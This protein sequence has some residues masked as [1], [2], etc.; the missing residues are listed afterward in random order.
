VSDRKAVGG[1]KSFYKDR[2]IRL[3]RN[4]EKAELKRQQ[5][6]PTERAHAILRAGGLADF[7]FF[8]TRILKLKF[9]PHVHGDIAHALQNH[10]ALGIRQVL[11][12]MARGHF[13]STLVAA[14]LAW[15]I[16]RDRDT[17][18]IAV[19]ASEPGAKKVGRQVIAFLRTPLVVA[20][21]GAFEGRRDLSESEFI[22]EGRS[23]ALRDATF[24]AAG[25][26]NFRPGPHV[27]ALALDDFEDEYTTT[28]PEM[29]AKGQDMDAQMVPVTDRDGS[30]RIVIGTFKSDSDL[31]C[32]LEEKYELLDEEKLPDGRTIKVR[33]NGVIKNGCAYFYKPLLLEDGT[34]LF[35]E[36]FPPEK[37]AQ[38]KWDM[39]FKPALFAREY[40]LDPVHQETAAF[41]ESDFPISS[42]CPFPVEDA[43]TYGAFDLANT[44]G[45]DSARTGQILFHI[46][47]NFTIYVEW[48][49]GEKMDGRA[50]M[51][52]MFRIDKQYERPTL[53][54]E[55]ENYVRGWKI[56]FEERMRA[57][58]NYLRTVY[59]SAHSRQSKESRILGLQGVLRAGNVTFSPECG[60][61]IHELLRFP[62]AKYRD[63]ADAF[64]LGMEVARSPAEK[65]RWQE[66]EKGIRISEAARTLMKSYASNGDNT[67]MTDDPKAALKW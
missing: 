14:F 8:S 4:D 31:H 6:T 55:E 47:P 51:D 32:F 42:T 58:R 3:N 29:I 49:R 40:M 34:P 30:I 62:E 9:V 22:V 56:G 57:E 43:F 5:T 54:I 52:M 25:R 65:K 20:L 41:K 28:T 35:P 67:K 48:A 12:L 16:V 17:R 13:K 38:I 66:Y 60:D 46:G 10:R 63:V 11:I 39:R 24:T 23:G 50:Q 1:Q 37:I 19:S 44:V 18:E 61:L 15:L 2:K 21:Y 33:R 64:A 27:E 59:L 45:Q 36:E 53:I 7:W 26:L